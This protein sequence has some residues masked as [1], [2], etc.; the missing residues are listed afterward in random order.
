MMQQ[1]GSGPE[2][3]PSS[4]W[5][6]TI[7]EKGKQNPTLHSSHSIHLHMATLLLQSIHLPCLEHQKNDPIKEDYSQLCGK[8]EAQAFSEMSNFLKTGEISL[9]DVYSRLAGKNFSSLAPCHAWKESFSGPSWCKKDKEEAST[10]KP[11]VMGT[12]RRAPTQERP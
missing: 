7:T 10:H 12:R 5:P 3:T 2:E 11:N 8:N 4:S 6:A 1:R 9:A